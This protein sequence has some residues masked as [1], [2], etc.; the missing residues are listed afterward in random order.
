[1]NVINFDSADDSQTEEEQQLLL[2]SSDDDE[3]IMAVI[4]SELILSSRD[5]R[6]FRTRLLWRDHVDML[7][8]E[9]QFATAS[10]KCNLFSHATFGGCKCSQLR[11]VL[12]PPRVKICTYATFATSIRPGLRPG[13]MRMVAFRICGIFVSH[14][15]SSCSVGLIGNPAL[16][17]N[18]VAFAETFG[19]WRSRME[20]L[21]YSLGIVQTSFL[22]GG[23]GA[24]EEV[25]PL[26]HHR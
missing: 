3:E 7:E 11:I 15:T 14:A 25:E 1:M 12:G 13:R 9:N 22:P 19:Y 8:R 23:R 18:M 20:D 6:V 10:L 17:S 2:E 5:Q 26:G 16:H 21:P 4:Y 24:G